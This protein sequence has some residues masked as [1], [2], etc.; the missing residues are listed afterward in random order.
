MLRRRLERESQLYGALDGALKFVK[1][2]AIA[3]IVITLVNFVGGVSL[4]VF[5]RDLELGESLATYGLLTIGDGL[6]TQIPALL[7]ATAAGLV[8]TRVAP[9]DEEGSLARDIA[10]QL[11]AEPRALGVAALVLAGLALVPALPAWPFVLLAALSV[12]GSIVATRAR[13]ATRVRAGQP[14]SLLSLE[15]SRELYRELTGRDAKAFSAAIQ[16]ERHVLL[17]TLGVELPDAELVR[18]PALP[19]RSFRWLWREL[20]ASPAPTVAATPLQAIPLA[21]AALLRDRAAECLDLDTVQRMLDRLQ[22]EQPTLVRLTVPRPVSFAQLAQV[23]R[24]LVAEGVSI[25]WLGEILEV[26][27]APAAA[28]ATPEALAEHARRALARRISHALAPAGKLHV[29]RLA[30]EVEETLADA[31]RRHG[32]DEILAL[33]PDLAREV[34]QAVV[35]AHRRAP[36]PHVLVTLAELRRHVRK[37]V[38][39]VVPDLAVVS[40]HELIPELEL[41]LEEPIGP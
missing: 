2:D 7:G 40:A 20:P 3:G 31:V 9:D 5:A 32:S 17:A 24:L 1:G 37:L 12:T 8:V 18:N 6:V 4:G 30:P 16:H 14:R 36:A 29:L 39:E 33:P 11:M 15:L 34:E 28:G 23:L 38:A 25:R 27:A 10:A 19:N 26:I 41:S 13:S 21:L 22:R 35:A